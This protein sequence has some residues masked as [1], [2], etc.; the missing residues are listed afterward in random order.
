MRITI[1]C[2]LGFIGALFS[3]PILFTQ[4]AWSIGAGYPPY[5]AVAVII[6]IVCMVALWHMKRWAAITYAAY[7]VLTQIPLMVAGIWSLF[8]LVIPGIAVAIVLSKYKDME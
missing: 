4:R 7:A 8:A 3:V 2:V 6:G 5:A 1:V